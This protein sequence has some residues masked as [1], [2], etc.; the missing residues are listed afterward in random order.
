M[1]AKFMYFYQLKCSTNV[2]L[3]VLEDIQNNENINR[4][5]IY[6]NDSLYHESNQWMIK[7]WDQEM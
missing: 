7:Q 5:I 4:F 6:M 3:Y 1:N 2:P